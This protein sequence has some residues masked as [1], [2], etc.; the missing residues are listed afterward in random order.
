M[1]AVTVSTKGD[2]S[3]CVRGFNRGGGYAV[4]TFMCGL[5]TREVNL[6]G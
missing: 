3:T 4:F 1:A 2:H 5:V 6:E